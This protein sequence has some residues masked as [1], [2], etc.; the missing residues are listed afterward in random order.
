MAIAVR[1]VTDESECVQGFADFFAANTR[2]FLCALVEQDGFLDSCNVRGLDG[3]AEISPLRVVVPAAMSLVFEFATSGRQAR[4]ND[5]YDLW[6]VVSA[7]AGDVFLTYDK[8]LAQLLWRAPVDGFRVV[9]SIEAL[10]AGLETRARSALQEYAGSERTARHGFLGFFGIHT[11][12]CP[13]RVA[14]SPA[15]PS[16]CVL[17]AIIPSSSRLRAKQWTAV[18]MVAR[19][20]KP[21][22]KSSS[23]TT[24]P[25]GRLVKAVADTGGIPLPGPDRLGRE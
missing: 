9:D 17:R 4:G 6:H 14:S 22:G 12:V 8:P 18:P 19:C 15:R 16:H 3:L 7:S 2:Q 13:R 23:T 10:L 25:K 5:V 21:E 1:L 11:A 20:S 24:K